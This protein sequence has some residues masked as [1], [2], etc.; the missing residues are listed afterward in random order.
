M[1]HYIE[2]GHKE[3]C[4]RD[5]N[6]IFRIREN[7]KSANSKICMQQY[8]KFFKSLYDLFNFRVIKREW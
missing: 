2:N 6:S 3:T 8:T 1:R 4:D 5:D 7:I